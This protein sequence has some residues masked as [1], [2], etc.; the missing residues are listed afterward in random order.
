MTKARKWLTADYWLDVTERVARTLPQAALAGW[1]ASAAATN[2]SMDFDNLF[3][4]ATAKGTVSGAVL[5]LLMALVGGTV[6]SKDT[7]SFVPQK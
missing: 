6:G 3:T 5:A 4:T 2:R 1:T 7:A